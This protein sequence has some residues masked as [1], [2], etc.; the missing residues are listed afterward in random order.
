MISSPEPLRTLY[1]SFDK[2]ARK[3]RVYKVETV[4]DCYVAVCGLP[5]AREDHAVVICRFARD[6]L[7]KM[8]VLT[9][10]LEIT[11]GPGT[12]ELGLRIGIHSG[13]VT[14]GVLRGER[15]RFQLF[16]DT[17]NTCSRLESTGQ[18]NRIHTSK[19]TAQLLVSAGKEAWLEKVDTPSELKG[20]G[21]F[22]T[23]FVNPHGDRAVTVMSSFD[24][25]VN[26]SVEL[27]RQNESDY[28]D[29]VPGLD[30]RTNRLINWNVEMLLQLMKQVTASRCKRRASPTES[31]TGELE[32]RKQ[33]LD[34]VREII[35]LPEFDNS[36]VRSNAGDVRL[37]REVVQQ[38]HLLVS[39]IALMYND[40]P[41]HNFG[42]DDLA[43][44][45]V[46]LVQYQ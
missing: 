29:D 11:L 26:E 36:C 23:F 3:R 21:L 30:E 32:L 25:T 45:L 35:V 27:L 12:G 16:G 17:M 6:M 40:N 9:K 20:K 13:P 46:C 2:I 15:A 7:A 1:Q 37:P 8:N 42:T 38:L 24:I 28:Y 39:K 34:E 44:L 22:Q 43:I 14:A 4:G 10:E 41:F 33:P 31:H 5:E 19:L 18:P